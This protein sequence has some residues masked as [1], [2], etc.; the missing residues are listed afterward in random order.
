[1]TG[2][3]C[4]ILRNR[5]FGLCGNVV[6]RVKVKR[7]VILMCTGTEIVKGDRIVLYIC[8]EQIVWVV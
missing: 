5:Y 4:R 6:F 7:T 3:C 2:L 1:V 8:T